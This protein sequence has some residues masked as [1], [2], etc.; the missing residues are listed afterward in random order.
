MKTLH[1]TASQT[2]WLFLLLGTMIL[3]SCGLNRQTNSMKAL[4]QCKFELVGVDSLSLAGTDIRSLLDRGDIDLTRMPAVALSF[5]SGELP[6]YSLLQIQVNNPTKYHAGLRQFR[7]EVLMDG[8]QV[9]DG[10]SDLPF[11]IQP[12]STDTVAVLIQANV[13]QLLADRTNRDKILALI[14]NR[15]ASTSSI[16]SPPP[17]INVTLR[18]KPTMG[19]GEKS[20][21]YPGYV[22]LNKTLD[23]ATIERWLQPHQR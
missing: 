19:L 22:T 2:M 3:S 18:I 15:K 13:Y 12:K 1:H 5:L 4:R 6:L 21:N 8:Q 14:D 16:Q 7:Y 10:T 20:I 9:I 11:S 23:R 17:S